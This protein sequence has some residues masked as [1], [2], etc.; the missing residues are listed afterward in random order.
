[1]ICNQTI[2]SVL[3]SISAKYK[4]EFCTR[5]EGSN[6][7][8]TRNNYVFLAVELNKKLVSELKS[9][10]NSYYEESHISNENR[11][12]F[13]KISKVLSLEFLDYAAC[14]KLS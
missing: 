3:I 11:P 14:L 5:I 6:S 9:I 13:D 8:G 1:M 7:A 12:K 10:S 4:K 2:E